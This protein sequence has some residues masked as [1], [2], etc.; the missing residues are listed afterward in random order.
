MGETDQ[1]IKAYL[2]FQ[3]RYPYD[4]LSPEV[5]WKV[6]WL[7][8]NDRQVDKAI[9]TYKQLNRRYRNNRFRDEVYF[10]IGLDYYREGDYET[11]RESWKS[12][13]RVVRE[14]EQRSRL[15]YWI[16]KCYAAVQ[17]YQKQGEIYI[18]LARRPVDSFYNL[19]AF[20]LTS[21]GGDIHNKTMEV[22]WK[23]HSSNQSFLQ[24]EMGSFRRA[25]IVK[26]I[27]GRAWGDL[28]LQELKYDPDEWEAVFA[29]G[30]LH[31]RMGNYGKA[32]RKFR[33]IFNRHFFHADL[34]DMI[35]IFK[36][37]YPFYFSR[38]V[39]EMAAEFDVPEALI[40]SV[41]KKESA[42]EPEIISYA[43]A[44]G[45]MQLL[46]GTASQLAP[47]L[48]MRFTSTR[49]LY[50]PET[51]IK[52]GTYY[53][54]TLL[55]KFENNPVMAL[56]AYNAGPHRVTRWRKIYPEKDSDLFME[57]IEFEQTRVYVRTCLKY[58]WLYKAIMNP[59]EIPK[60]IVRYPVKISDLIR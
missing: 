36:K 14:N 31:E 20:Y 18:E 29:L 55:K 46:P 7:Y 30:E 24:R 38:Y 33:S 34:P 27:L 25:L 57:N 5:L 47:R 43:N 17:D 28:E 32:F 13:L 60:E 8:E 56:A 11:A 35:P 52:M 39:E 54:S 42:F 9:H 23:L 58:Y 22:L 59:G 10:R 51:N 6:A 16:G 41:I 1:S 19:K 50:E 2:N 15:Q 48:H 12:A 49:Q 37:L 26:E 44:Y 40:Y 4:S 21:N 45:L 53:L 3:K